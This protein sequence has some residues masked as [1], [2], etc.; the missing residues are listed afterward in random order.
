[1]AANTVLIT[2]YA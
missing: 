2:N 1:M